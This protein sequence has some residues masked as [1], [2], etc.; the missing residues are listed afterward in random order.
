ME[1]ARGRAPAGSTAA[2]AVGGVALGWGLSASGLRLAASGSAAEWVLF[3]GACAADGSATDG[4]TT[5]G[6]AASSMRLKRSLGCITDPALLP[7]LVGPTGH[8]V[9]RPL[10]CNKMA[11]GGRKITSLGTAGWEPA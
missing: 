4:A 9:S 3:A 8:T 7:D 5:A 6:L 2:A 1:G 10:L 11:G